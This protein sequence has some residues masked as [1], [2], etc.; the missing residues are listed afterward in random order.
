MTNNNNIEV[1]SKEYE[2]LVSELKKDLP[3]IVLP[4]M[5]MLNDV[6]KIDIDGSNYIIKGSNYEEV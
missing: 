3:N 4:S 1:I 2:K 6:E 5:G